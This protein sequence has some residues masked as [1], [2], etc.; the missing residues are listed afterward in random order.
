VTDVDASQSVGAAAG[1]PSRVAR[2]RPRAAGTAVLVFAVVGS[3]IAAQRLSPTDTGLQLL[4]NALATTGALAVLILVFGP[5]SGAHFN[6]IVSVVSWRL[7]ALAGRDVVPYSGAQVLG[8][9]IGTVIANVT[10]GLD[11]VTI[12]T[13]ARA[14]GRLGLAEVI[15]TAALLVVIFGCVRTGRAAVVPWAVGGWIGSA[16]FVMASTSFANPA[17]T[18]A[19]TLSDTFAGIRPSSVPMFVGAQAIG[20]I[21]AI[22]AIRAWF[23][24]PRRPS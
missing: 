23:P 3:G 8:G 7:D 14:A 21:V 20:A 24:E 2:P 1:T 12:S 16:Y 22:P 19:R 9:C 13:T 11:P 18:I 17:V 10:F 15:A 6:P 5:V 4:E